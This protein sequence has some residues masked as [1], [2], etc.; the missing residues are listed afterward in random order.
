M[1]R[2][3]S[4]RVCVIGAGPSGITAAKNL[5]Q[6]GAENIVVYEAGDQ[7]GGNWIF[8]TESSHSSVYESTH[9][10][11]SKTMSGLEDYPMPEGYPDYPSHRQML[12][13]FQGYARHFGV[14]RFIRFNCT[15][16]RAEKQADDTWAITLDDGTVETF[17]TLMVANGHH[18]DP[19]WPDYPGT[20]SGQFLHSHQY[21]AA[22]PFRDQRVLI[23]GG[24]NSGCDIAVATGQ[25][26]AMTALSL[27]RGYHIIPKFLFGYPTDVFNAR[28]LAIPVGIRLAIFRLLLRLLV[29]RP[30][31]DGLPKP[32][33]G[34]LQSHPVASSDLL[35]AIRH[36][37]VH[38]RPDVQRFEGRE[39]CFVD[40]TV[41]SYDAVIAATGFKISFPFFDSAFID[42]S[43]GEVP[44]YL[45]TFHPDHPSLFF[46]GLVQPHG[47]TWP[48]SDLQAKLAANTIVGNYD[49]PQ[50]MRQRIAREV[51][52]M[53]RRFIRSARHT[54]EVD[55]HDYRREL[56]RQMPDD[57]P[58]WSQRS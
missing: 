35:N 28:S 42:Y 49:P 4:A 47:A 43:S 7:V 3:T 14:E 20:F 8:S 38:P 2:D 25:V 54:L 51:E 55:Y 23:I 12:A 26:S 31:Q 10:I 56:L 46:I 15:V 45:R 13:Y 41:E 36:G 9:I 5:L 11:S 39:V 44:L 24:G 16:T 21:K 37:R 48:L 27:R 29:G 58:E 53:S 34:L 32:D 1:K 33:H 17:D 22:A 18:W 19:R 6:V 40:G 30:E 52:I 50:D 57:A